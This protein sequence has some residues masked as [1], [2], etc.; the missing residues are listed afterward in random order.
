MCAFIISES[1]VQPRSALDAGFL[2][3]F[4][5]PPSAFL[6]HPLME[7]GGNQ[8]IKDVNGSEE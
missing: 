1:L 5:F 8:L 4:F 7:A 6:S 2:S 3:F